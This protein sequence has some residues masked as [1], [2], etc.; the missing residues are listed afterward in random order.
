M[1]GTAVRAHAAIKKPIYVST[2]HK[3]SLQTAVSL[4]QQCCRFRVPQPIREADIR[5]RQEL[6]RWCGAP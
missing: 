6:A 3:V 5:G 2:G 1:L 4:V